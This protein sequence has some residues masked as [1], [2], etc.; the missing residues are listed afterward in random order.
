[1]HLIEIPFGSF[2]NTLFIFYVFHSSS[3]LSKNVI[4][5]YSVATSWSSF[6]CFYF[7]LS[8]CEVCYVFKML[9][10]NLNFQSIVYFS[11]EAYSETCIALSEKWFLFQTFRQ[12]SGLTFSVKNNGLKTDGILTIVLLNDVN[13]TQGR[14]H[15]KKRVRNAE[16]QQFI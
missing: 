7:A 16:Y 3:W 15:F 8:K 13:Q 9:F 2:I 1:M 14:S 4:Y 10:Q 12:P 11:N 5:R 6:Y